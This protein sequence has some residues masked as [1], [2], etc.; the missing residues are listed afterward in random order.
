MEAAYFGRAGTAEVRLSRGDKSIC[1]GGDTLPARG[2]GQRAR[3]P[4]S[5]R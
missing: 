1:L 3:R 2:P 5:W 4:K